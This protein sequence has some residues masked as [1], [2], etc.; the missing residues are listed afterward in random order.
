MK[1]YMLSL[2]AWILVGLIYSLMNVRSPA[3]PLVAL[4]GRLGT[5][6]GEQV[7]PVARQMLAGSTLTAASQEAKSAPHIFG[8][9]PGRHAD[10]D[11]LIHG[12]SLERRS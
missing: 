8:M 4:I 11:T 2:G 6:L 5:L 10:T 9:L 12:N 3:P 7:I 1:A